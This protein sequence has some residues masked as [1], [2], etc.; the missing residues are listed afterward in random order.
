[1]RRALFMLFIGLAACTDEVGTGDTD[2]GVAR[3]VRNGD[4]LNGDHFNGTSLGHAVQWASFENVRNGN[5]HY[6]AMWLEGSQLVARK[7]R[8]RNRDVYRGEA[9]TGAIVQGR[10]DTDRHVM[11]RISKV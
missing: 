4:S 2:Q 5:V 7:W 8:G 1:M 9:L 10:S 6:D 3:V 11:M